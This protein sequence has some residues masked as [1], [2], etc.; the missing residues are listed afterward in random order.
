MFIEPPSSWDPSMNKRQIPLPIEHLHGC[1]LLYSDNKV[2][3]EK[4]KED[5]K[6]KRSKLEYGK[7]YEKKKERW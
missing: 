2:K 7:L 5:R 3:E 6:E 4:E 1:S